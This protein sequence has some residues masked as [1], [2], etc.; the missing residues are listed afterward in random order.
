MSSQSIPIATVSPVNQPISNKDNLLTTVKNND[1]LIMKQNTLDN[2]TNS[3]TNPTI[4]NT[5]NTLNT[6]NIPDSPLIPTTIT[7][8]NKDQRPPKKLHGNNYSI[9]SKKTYQ[10]DYDAIERMANSYIESIENRNL[11]FALQKTS[12]E[13][14]LDKHKSDVKKAKLAGNDEEKVNII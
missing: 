13:K 9:L 14:I 8:E 3:P 5:N 2:I 1:N 6:P 10:R 11:G 4:P 7:N 12:V